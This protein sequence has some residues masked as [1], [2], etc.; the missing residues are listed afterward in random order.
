MSK[1]SVAVAS[2]SRLNIGSSSNL[3]WLISSISMFPSVNDGDAFLFILFLSF[4]SACLAIHLRVKI[5]ETI[6]TIAPHITVILMTTVFLLVFSPS[7]EY[8]RRM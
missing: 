5:T 7:S 4:L 6:M 8:A 1:F 3:A 2:I